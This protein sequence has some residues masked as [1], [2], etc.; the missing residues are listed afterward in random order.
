MCSALVLIIV[1]VFTTYPSYV[2]FATQNRTYNFN[3]N[4]TLTGDGA[5]DILRIAFA[6]V[7]RKGSDFGYTENWCADFVSDC[8]DLA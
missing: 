2:V 6:Q 8:A 1:S 3:N 7:G 4:Y 5:T